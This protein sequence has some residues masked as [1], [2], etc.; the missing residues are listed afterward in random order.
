MIM[1]EQLAEI[2]DLI[3]AGIPYDREYELLKLLTDKSKDKSLWMLAVELV[4]TFTFSHLKATTSLV[5]TTLKACLILPEQK[6][7]TSTSC[8][9]I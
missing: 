5:W 1:Y 2:Y 4:N 6:I 8:T 7:R 3:N 9:E